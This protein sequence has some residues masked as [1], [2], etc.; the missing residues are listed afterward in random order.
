MKN[1]LLLFLLGFAVNSSLHAQLTNAD[2]IKMTKAQLSTDIILSKVASETPNYKTDIDGLIELK[3]QKVAETVINLMV[4]KQ[5]E[6]SDATSLDA[7]NNGDG[8]G[9]IFEESG[10]Y[11]IE[12]NDY[13][14]LDPTNTT[15]NRGTGIFQSKQMV[16]LEGK[17]ANYSLNKDVEFYFNFDDATKSL[18]SSNAGISSQGGNMWFGS[19]QAVSPNEFKLVKLK[20]SLSLLQ[21]KK[22]QREYVAGKISM[23]GKVDWSIDSKYIIGFKYEKVSGNTYKVYVQGGLPP[24]QYCFVYT[25]NNNGLTYLSQNMVKVYDFGIE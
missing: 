3:T 6:A 16:Q 1:L 22:E 8:E 24:G 15:S 21:G 25:G 17:E 13:S 14:N 9:H 2:V 20:Q 10:I 4:S 7:E 19:S 18:N 5:K 23:M 12:N 11:F